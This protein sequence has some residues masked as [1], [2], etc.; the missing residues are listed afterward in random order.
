[1]ENQE[2]EASKVNQIFSNE[3]FYG[4]AQKSESV[5]NQPPVAQQNF[6]EDS[7]SKPQ[8]GEFESFFDINESSNKPIPIPNVMCSSQHSTTSSKSHKDQPESA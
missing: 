5:N 6:R 4:G 8:G 2:E 1:M 7:E 3:G